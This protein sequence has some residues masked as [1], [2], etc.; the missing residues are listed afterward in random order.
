MDRIIWT[1]L[2]LI[3]FAEEKKN[4]F[5]PFSLVGTKFNGRLNWKWFWKVISTFKVQTHAHA[6]THTHANAHTHTHANKW[7]QRDRVGGKRGKLRMKKKWSKLFGMTARNSDNI[8]EN[9]FL[10][11]TFF[12]VANFSFENKKSS[13][14]IK[15]CF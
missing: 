11:T 9:D 10:E 13:F 2:W 12:K 3:F 14:H 5:N 15:V 8:F 7:R 1:N 6:R 4:F